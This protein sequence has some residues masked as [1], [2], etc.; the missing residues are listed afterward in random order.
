VEQIFKKVAKRYRVTNHILSGGLDI[1]WRKRLVK[2]ISKKPKMAI[3]DLACGG[4]ELTRELS[5]LKPEKLIGADISKEMLNNARNIDAD[6][7]QL[8]GN[9][10]LF[11][12]NSFDLITIAFG[13]RNFEAR[14]KSLKECFRVLRQDGEIAI[15]EF[16]LPKNR[17]LRTI[18]K[19]HLKHFVPIIG[20]ICSG[21][22]APYRYLGCSIIHFSIDNLK[23]ELSELGFKIDKQK[24]LFPYICTIV[25]AKKCGIR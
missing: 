11:P 23:S 20:R 3:L 2:S 13:V 4:G 5:K 18:Y 19:F 16:S 17:F 9:E 6:F 24:S 21:S 12:D 7:L 14:Q 10:L 8:Y 1:V 22:S 25:T 15:L